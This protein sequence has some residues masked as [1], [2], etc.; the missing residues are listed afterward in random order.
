MS[1]EAAEPL[2]VLWISHLVPWPPQGGVL[3]RSFNLLRQAATRH[4]VVLAAL[5]QRAILPTADEVARA[6]AELEP[7]C[8]EVRVCEIPSNRS[9]L[10]WA[11][12]AAASVVTRQPYDVN[13]LW[14]PRMHRVVAEL[15]ASRRFD[16]VHLD[17][18][19]LHPYAAGFA[20]TPRVLNHHNVESD[21]MRLRA[22][23]ERHPLKRWYFALQGSKLERLER[24]AA[25]AAAVNVVVSDL[26]G[27]R[28]RGVAPG[29][30]TETVPNGVDIGYFQPQ[31]AAAPPARSLVFVGGMTWYPNH[32]AMEFFAREIWPRLLAASPDWKA[33]I[34]GRSPTPAVRAAVRPGSLE[35]PGFVDDARPCFDAAAIYLCPIRRGGGTRL[36]IL[37]A[38]AMAKPLVA[39]GFAVEGLDLVAEQDYL[40]AETPDEFVAQL[41]RLAASP[42][43]RRRLAHNARR[44]AEERFAW[45]IIGQRLDRAYRR[46]VARG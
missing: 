9:R 17:T 37:D 18:V 12:M 39:T 38:L 5:N 22:A 20:R 8:E 26:D 16:V 23:E 24:E 30:R 28:M 32:D 10:L 15:R 2:R 36:K 42:E 3:Q 14:S 41:E 25:E 43:L 44:I 21:M 31:S 35:A 4:S 34:V 40:R 13:W 46:A 7:L 45:E 19:G 11:G 27:E 1:G 29:C 6:V 33:T